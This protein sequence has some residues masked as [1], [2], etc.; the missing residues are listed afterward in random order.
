MPWL[1]RP[2]PDPGDRLRE[3]IATVYTIPWYI[4][5]FLVFR[6]LILRVNENFFCQHNFTCLLF[7]FQS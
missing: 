1:S 4:V 7:I 3:K 5:V 2:C 6:A